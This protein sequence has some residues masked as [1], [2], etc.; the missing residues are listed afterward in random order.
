MR[1][2]DQ[3]RRAIKSCGLSR[4]RIA[5]EADVAE[6]SLSRFLAKEHG[7]TTETLDRIAEV[8]GL[9]VVCRGPRKGLVAR[10]GSERGQR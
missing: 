4:Y 7:L 1:L 3:I 5:A 8:L 6:S 10:Y 2:S 9:E